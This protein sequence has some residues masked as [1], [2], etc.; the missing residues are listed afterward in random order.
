[1]FHLVFFHPPLS[2]IP[3]SLTQ[4]N[5]FYLS[6]GSLFD[7]L[8]K[9]TYTSESLLWQSNTAE[10]K[11]GLGWNL[12]SWETDLQSQKQKGSGW[13]EAEL[14]S[15]LTEKKKERPGMREF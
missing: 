2:F 8:K 7:I 11:I 14:I 12:H 3:T 5:H 9:V 10:A 4:F 13:G 1:M 6:K 15:V